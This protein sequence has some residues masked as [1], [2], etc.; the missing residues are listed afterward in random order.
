MAERVLE[1]LGVP[2]RYIERGESKVRTGGTICQVVILVG[3]LHV[4]ASSVGQIRVCLGNC[5]CIIN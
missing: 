2:G 1:G 4:H 5:C 3:I